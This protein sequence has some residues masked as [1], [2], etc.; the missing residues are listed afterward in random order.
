MKLHGCHPDIISQRIFSFLQY[1]LL[2]FMAKIVCWTTL[3]SSSAYFLKSGFMLAVSCY[4][5]TSIYK[6]SKSLSPKRGLTISPWQG[7]D[8]LRVSNS[9]GTYPA[10]AQYSF[11]M[12]L[13]KIFWLTYNI[14]IF[15]PKIN[16]LLYRFYTDIS[17]IVRN[18]LIAP[19]TDDSHTRISYRKWDGVFPHSYIDL[20]RV[21]LVSYRITATF[22]IGSTAPHSTLMSNISAYILLLFHPIN[23]IFLSNTLMPA[24]K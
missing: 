22:L 5:L 11:Y 24:H 12:P 2:F 16:W 7:C 15:L 9:L 6:L 20:H 3:T 13:H 8:T 23:L 17:K 10:Q 14:Y 21:L 1:L 4:T 18:F 19:N